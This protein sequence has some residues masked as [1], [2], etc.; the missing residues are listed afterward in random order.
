MSESKRERRS[1]RADRG[2]TSGAPSSPTFSVVASGENVVLVNTH[3]GQ[4]WAM[5]TDAGRPV[6]HPVAFEGG[7][8]RAP[9]RTEGKKGESED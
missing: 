8:V 4:T 7:A 1:G 9:R 2:A 3:T 6:W 5:G